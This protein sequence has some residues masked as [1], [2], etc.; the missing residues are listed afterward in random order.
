MAIH[1]GDHGSRAHAFLFLRLVVCDDT[2][3]KSIVANCIVITNICFVFVIIISIPNYRN[4]TVLRLDTL[5][6]VIAAH[7]ALP[8]TRAVAALRCVYP[9]HTH[10]ICNVC[11]AAQGQLRPFPQRPVALTIEHRLRKPPR[12]AF[13]GQTFRW[14]TRP[15]RAALGRKLVGDLFARIAQGM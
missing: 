7:V 6:L 14:R 10:I 2:T 15:A 4:S 8:F 13:I 12:A 11:A 3:R 9:I 5:R 1:C